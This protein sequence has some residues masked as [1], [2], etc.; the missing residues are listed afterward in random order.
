MKRETNF[1]IVHVWRPRR[2]VLA[3]CLSLVMWASLIAGV[4]LLIR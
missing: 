3:I 4:A 2:L 1:D